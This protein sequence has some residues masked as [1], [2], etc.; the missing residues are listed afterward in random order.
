LPP[1]DHIHYANS[2]YKGDLEHFHHHLGYLKKRSQQFV[3]ISGSHTICNVNFKE[4]FHAHIA[5][6]AD[7]TVLY[8]PARFNPGKT[9][10]LAT[11]LTLEDDERV[12]D[13]EVSSSQAADGNISMEMFIMS[14][15]LLIQIIEDC[16][17][18]GEYDLMKG[19][20]VR[21]LGRYKIYGFPFAG[22]MAKINSV[23]VYYR[24]SMDLLN[25]EVWQ[26]LFCEAAP[27][28]TKIK[29]TAPANYRATAMVSNSLVANGCIIEGQVE[30]SLLFRGVK[31]HHGARVKNSII[32]QDCDIGPDVVLENVICDKD[33]VVRE[34]KHLMGANDYLL[35][36][37]KGV[38]V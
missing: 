8:Q 33:V 28:Y 24:T 38:V 13:M 4:V 34:G 10:A 5:R 30:N 6:Q 12:V 32:M 2:I 11:T 23:P 25:Q 9:F 7:I 27:I 29:D 20:I 22:Y 31:I 18:R 3:L 14:K 1:P 21:N 17:A 15:A 19:G 26:E 36:V 37:E 35:V 16:I